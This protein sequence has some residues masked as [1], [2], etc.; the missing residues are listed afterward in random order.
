MG[1]NTIV[2]SQPWGGLGDNLQFSTL[3][4]LYT[5]LGFDVYISS[6]NKYRNNEIY[7]LV[8]K[9]NPYI[10]GIS[11]LPINAGASKGISE[12]SSN[13]VKNMEISHNL[14]NGT[15]KY[16]KLYYTPKYI[17]DLSNTIL[18]DIT[19]ITD[20]YT[21][22]VITE[23]FTNIFNKYPNLTKKKVIF[24]SLSNRTTPNLNTDIFTVNNIYEYCDAIYSCKVHLSVMSGSVCL[25]SALKE[26]N[27]F[28]KIY[29]VHNHANQIVPKKG[30]MYFFDNVTFIYKAN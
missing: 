15:R 6:S 3:P 13:P 19:S 7:D 27:E 26:D 17:Q 11:E 30:T 23:T 28:P 4:E 24:S 22:E 2:I 29:C 20:T 1:S 5:E 10:K 16:L 8:W 18:Y 25:A 14:M 21:D 12:L 9:L